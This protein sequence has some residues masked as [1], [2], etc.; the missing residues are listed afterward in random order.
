MA[1]LYDDPTGQT[2]SDMAFWGSRA[3]VGNYNGFRIYDVTGFTPRRLVDFVCF[4]PQND[5]TVWD[6][7]RDGEADLLFASWTA[8]SPAAVRRD[9]D[10]GARRPGRMGGHPDLR[11]ERP[12]EPAADRRGVPG[13]RVAHAHAGAGPQAQPRA[14][15]QRVVPAASRPDVRPGPRS[16]GRSRP[17]A[18][19]RADRRGAAGQPGRRARDRRAAGQLP[20]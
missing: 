9:G 11:R 7:D 1:L 15:L 3:F 14:A 17:A 18:R 16:G 8:R 5:V 19:R 10:R 4:G 6:S 13:L 12:E 20:G 2:N